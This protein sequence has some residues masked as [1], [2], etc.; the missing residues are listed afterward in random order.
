MIGLFRHFEYLGGFGAED[1]W[2]SDRTIIT[3][4]RSVLLYFFVS[5]NVVFTLLLSVGKYFIYDIYAILTES[6]LALYFFVD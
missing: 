3:P 1:I 6:T 2:S 4:I 5:A